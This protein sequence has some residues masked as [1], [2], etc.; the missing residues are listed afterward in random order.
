MKVKIYND[1]I[2]IHNGDLEEFLEENQYDPEIV[3]ICK[4]LQN[5]D[6]IEFCI[7]QSGWWK[8]EKYNY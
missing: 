7:S 1:N 3:E 4:E 2:L 8:I 6:T 5:K